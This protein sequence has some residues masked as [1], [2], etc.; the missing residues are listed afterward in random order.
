MRD[1]RRYSERILPAALARGRTIAQAL[2]PMEPLVVELRLPTAVGANLDR[3]KQ[4]RP[5][6]L[7]AGY[8]GYG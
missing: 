4:W 8:L 2:A 6:N 5:P 7:G 3:L 1:S